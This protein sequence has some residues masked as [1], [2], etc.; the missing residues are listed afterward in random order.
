[1]VAVGGIT[2]IETSAFATVSVVEPITPLKDAVIVDIPPV[3]AVA[4]PPVVIVA[5]EVLEESQ[6]AVEVRFL[7]VPSLNDPVAVNCCVAPGA[8]EGLAGVT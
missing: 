6:L 2:A 3:T 1:M 7:V 5:T 8:M 4:R